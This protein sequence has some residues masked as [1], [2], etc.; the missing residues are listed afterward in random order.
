MDDL[1]KLRVG[2]AA[3]L[4]AANLALFLIEKNGVPVNDSWRVGFDRDMATAKSAAVS[5]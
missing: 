1:E 2:L 4:R 3:A 5:T